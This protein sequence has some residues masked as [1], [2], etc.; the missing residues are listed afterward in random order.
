MANIDGRWIDTATIKPFTHKET[1]AAG[2]VFTHHAY[3]LEGQVRFKESYY[4]YHNA[5]E[6]WRKLQQVRNLPVRLRDYLPWV[7]DHCHA[8]SMDRPTIGKGVAPVRLDEIMGGGHRDRL[9]KD[10][11]PR[12]VIDGVIFQLQSKKSQGISRVWTNLIS[13]LIR[14]MPLAKITILQRGG[15]PVPEKD[16]DIRKV[17]AYEWNSTTLLDQDDEMLRDVCRDLKADLFISTYYTR[18]PGLT[19][20]V[21]MHDMIPEKFGFDLTQPEWMSKQRVIETADAFI[22]VSQ[23]TQKDFIEAYPQVA[24]RPMTVVYNGLDPSFRAPSKQ[25]VEKLKNHLNLNTPYVLMVGNRHG[26]KNGEGALKALAKLEAA[27]KPT[28]LCVGGET[29]LSPAEAGLRDQLDIRHAGYLDDHSLAAAY[30]GAMALL[31]PSKYEGFGLPVIEAMACGCPVIAL[32]TPAVV[33]I[34]GD[35]VCYTDL[36]SAGGIGKALKKILNASHRQAYIEK[37]YACAAEFDWQSSSLRL[38]TFIQ[39]VQKRP[40][41]LLTAIVSTYNAFQF[42]EGCL[43]DLEN[44]TIADQMEII[45]VDSASQQ[46]E[47]AVVRDFQSRH[48]NIKYIRT[49]VRESVYQAWNRGI[50]F[51]LGK[52]ISNA[53]TDDR[54]RRD[55]YELMVGALEDNNDI[56]LVYADVIKTQSANETFRDCTPTGM[57]RWYDW[58]RTTLLEK[59]CFIGPQPVWR[60]EVHR[61]YGY[62]D[63]NYQ[64]SS[65]FEFWLR[66]SQTN[67]FYHIPKPLG[68]YMDR[69]DSVEHVND[70]LKEREDRQIIKCY[71]QAAA[72]NILIGLVSDEMSVDDIY[73]AAQVKI[74]DGDKAAAISL[75]QKL[76]AQD[77]AHGLAHND[78]GVLNYE[79]GNMGATL[80]H[81]QRATEL[82]SENKTFQKNLADFYWSEIGDHQRALECYLQVL[83]LN[84]QDVDAHLGCGQI[85][86]SLGKLADARDFINIA[87]ETEPW[88]ENARMMHGQLESIAEKAKLS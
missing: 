13:E 62:F 52:Y 55:A 71:R 19:N 16:A 84:P 9:E 46:D 33:E 73:G 2:L 30:G 85:S 1:E 48:S 68:L 24:Q 43:E 76:I 82:I 21:M 28:V 74:K 22:C 50:K 49:P 42:I 64:I 36:E 41:I 63:E 11:G 59:G 79:S 60:K 40:S 87:L 75:L 23:T 69:P 65:D 66:V 61:Q 29:R 8:D 4:G 6:K 38:A 51:A 44:Q 72:K 88:N 81:Y 31:V 53:N 57:F 34:G 83:K 17:P 37:G 12:I 77:D 26:Y 56:A 80:K 3:S 20:L 14:Q 78:L 35:A 47:A 39:S 15:Y 32:E 86:L 67:D 27:D 45:V 58:D 25:E 5:V 10:N 7:K 70:S 54:H 18:A